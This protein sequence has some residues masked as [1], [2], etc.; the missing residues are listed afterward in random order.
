M[1]KLTISGVV[2]DL[3]SENIDLTVAEVIPKARSKGLKATDVSI[4]DAVYGIK[5]EL[6]KARA[7]TAP[8]AAHETAPPKKTAAPAAVPTA[9]TT[10][11]AAT[12]DLSAVLA[13]VALV[14]A[15]AGQCGGVE[16]ARRAAEAV[17]ACGGVEPFLQ[18]L[19]LVAGIRAAGAPG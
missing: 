2:R 10:P 15:V 5:A 7:R 4:R 9:P 8:A 14:N 12:I 19:D 3:L 6:K 1:S 16:N 11:A 17:R 18:H 13:N